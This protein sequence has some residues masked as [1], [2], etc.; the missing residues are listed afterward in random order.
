MSEWE[1]FGEIIPKVVS[2]LKKPPV[3]Y[4]GIEYRTITEI[5]NRIKSILGNVA[6]SGNRHPIGE[7]VAGEDGAFLLWGARHYIRE[8]FPEIAPEEIE[9]VQICWVG[10][11]DRHYGVSPHRGFKIRMADGR[12]IDI[13][14]TWLLPRTC[15][16]REAHSTVRE[17]A[18]IAILPAI[19]AFKNAAFGSNDK[20][21]SQYPGS[22]TVVDRL[23]CHVDH[24]DLTFDEALREFLR[25]RGM[26]ENDV[27][28]RWESEKAGSEAHFACLEFEQSWIEFHNA[29]THLR[30]V[31]LKENLSDAR[32]GR[33]HGH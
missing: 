10:A 19:R 31:S 20:I 9:A 26:T 24:Y 11:N 1:S 32:K 33:S 14:Q 5:R 6:S 16:R 3:V 2:R 4:A 22:T 28:L 18:R 8:H 7:D 17:A 21:P 13:G 25:Q 27:M 29:N 23:S 30:I 12:L 15:A